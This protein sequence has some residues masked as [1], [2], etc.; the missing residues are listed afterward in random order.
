[1]DTDAA[2][3]TTD[4]DQ[5]RASIPPMRLVNYG[6]AADDD[7]TTTK[8][9]T[10][11]RKRV[12]S[13]SDSNDEDD[14]AVKKRGPT[15]AYEMPTPPQQPILVSHSSTSAN[16][17]YTLPNCSCGRKFHF[18]A[19]APLSFISRMLHFS[20]YI[21]RLA[22]KMADLVEE[23]KILRQQ[24]RSGVILSHDVADVPFP[25]E[26]PVNSQDEYEA[27][28]DLLREEA[29]ESLLVRCFSA[30]RFSHFLINFMCC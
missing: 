6:N 11:K 22:G 25:M 30:M 3:D 8:K 26:L 17:T 2:F 18:V 4:V 9:S 7:D 5:K 24:V 23:M 13:C 10:K 15:S 16:S 20:A 29:N 1:M 27:L 28:N 12:I 14:E 21:K 19:A